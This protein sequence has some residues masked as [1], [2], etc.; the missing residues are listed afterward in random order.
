MKSHKYSPVSS[1]DWFAPHLFSLRFC[2][3][4][5]HAFEA[6]DL[7]ETI[8][9]ADI[10]VLG[11][12]Q[13]RPLSVWADWTG[14]G[15]SGDHFTVAKAQAERTLAEETKRLPCENGG[16]GIFS[17]LI[18]WY[19]RPSGIGL[20]SG[21]LGP[22]RTIVQYLPGNAHMPFPDIPKPAGP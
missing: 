14:R 10:G 4:G 7:L 15:D 13:M 6:V 22:F 12:S 1:W 16:F 11:G 19:V 21:Y 2:I 20:D 5:V 17:A 9:L 18:G 3:D 8:G